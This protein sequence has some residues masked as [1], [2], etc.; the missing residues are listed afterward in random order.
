MFEEGQE[1]LPLLTRSALCKDCHHSIVDQLACRL[2][3]AGR[4]ELCQLLTDEP[5]DWESAG[6]SLECVQHHLDNL[7][8]L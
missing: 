7:I 6:F 5:F 2:V 1:R 8:G 3:L 4:D